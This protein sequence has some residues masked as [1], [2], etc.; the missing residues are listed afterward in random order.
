MTILYQKN[1]RM[2]VYLNAISFYLPDIV[3]TNEE[4]SQEYP[5]WSVEKIT[6]KV[7]INQR[8]VVREDETAADLAYCAAENLIKQYGIDKMTIDYIIFCTQSPDYFLPTTACI[9]QDKLGLSIKCGAIDFNQGCS[10]FIYGLGLAKGLIISN[11]ATNVLLLTGE[12]YSKYINPRD[13]G[14]RT[15]FGDAGTATLISSK[16]IDKGFDYKILDFCYGTDGSGAENLIVRNGAAKHKSID[17]CD[18]FENETDFV[19]NDNNL[20]MDG[21]AIFNFTSFEIPTLVKET[22]AKNNLMFNTIDRFVFHQANEF[23]LQTVRKRCGI[24]E[25]KFY[26]NLK[27]VGNTVS[28]T[29]PIALCKAQSERVLCNDKY[30]LI[31]GFGVGLSMGATILEK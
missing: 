29:I 16:Q 3:V 23:M 4:I 13:K 19:R 25:A 28:N 14:N 26:I 6:S 5:E 27:A 7:G 20:Y 24:E 11:Q 21:R 8:H 12:T 9:L 22:I 17:G 30:I 1:N 18:V 31:A 2:D 15:L 10:G